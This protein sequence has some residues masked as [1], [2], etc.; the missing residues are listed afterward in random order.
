[1]LISFVRGG[2]V[3]GILTAVIVVIG[4]LLFK[5]RDLH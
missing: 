1:V 2:V 5:R 4:V 3:L